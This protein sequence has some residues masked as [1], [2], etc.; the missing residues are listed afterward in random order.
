MRGSY[1]GKVFRAEKH[2]GEVC[3][4]T[5]FKMG[6]LPLLLMSAVLLL[7]GCGRAMHDGLDTFINGG[8]DSQEITEY[9]ESHPKAQVVSDD[10]CTVAYGGPNSHGASNFRVTN[11]SDDKRLVTISFTVRNGK[12]A[13]EDDYYGTSRD[14]HSESTW[15]SCVVEPGETRDAY[16]SWS[17]NYPD[18]MRV[19][20]LNHAVTINEIESEVTDRDC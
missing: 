8:T 1:A 14:G 20:Y 10:Y 19:D 12:Y 9:I 6:F 16:G 2:G 15:C 3:V 5:V 7:S 4:G 18:G 17:E 13:Y 11:N